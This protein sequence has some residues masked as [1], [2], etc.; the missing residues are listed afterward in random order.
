MSMDTGIPG[1]KRTAWNVDIKERSDR[2]MNYFLVCYFLVGVGLASFY[3]TWFIAFGV[4]GL[5]LVAYYSVKKLLPGSTL[6]Q[7]VLSVAIGLYMA[8]FIYQ[9]HGMFEMHFFAF[10][11]CAVLI[12]YQNWK[13]QIPLLLTIAI[14]HIVFSLL[15][16]AGY[17]K[18]YFTQ[19]DSFD[20]P[21]FSIHIL[22][23][24]VISFICGLWAYQFRKYNEVQIRQTIQV[25]EL[26]KEAL[27]TI[28][29]KR[30]EEIMEER[31]TILESIADAFFAV[32]NNWVVT[33][34][35]NMAETV[36]KKSKEDILNKCLWDVYAS[37]V[38]SASYHK[39]H[40]ALATSRPVHF[41]T[42]YQVLNKWYDVTAYPSTQGLSVYIKD[43][44]ERK[45]SEILLL[46]SEQRYSNVFQLSPL[47]IWAFDTDTL[48]FL[49]VNEAAIEHYGY[50]REEFLSMTIKDIR[51]PEDMPKLDET[52]LRSRNDGRLTKQGIYRHKRKNGD[53]IEVDV[54]SSGFAY[55]GRKAKVIVA[56]DVTATLSYIKAIEE[57]N[58][59]LKEISWIQSHVI[60]APLARILGLVQ[61]V[62]EPTTTENE[63]IEMMEYITASANELDEAIRN[64]NNKTK[65]IDNI[66]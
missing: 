45:S 42:H 14:H 48:E 39:Y 1:M 30:N 43:I 17:S 63:K 23:T 18:V 13:L 56:N 4:G 25:Q 44:T 9:V 64:I 12:T 26:R 28:E 60:R 65:T 54:Q 46:E 49:D 61:L 16:N 27:L 47:P 20:L 5:L 15:Q 50:T 52:L 11:G 53:I 51:G 10:I 31:N 22:L 29:R 38:G 33:Y 21:T 3:D 7:Y 36:L 41:E 55:K 6:Y 59:K 40:E 2:L 57:Q 19:L 32:D 35:N 66:E 8:Q 37:S 62:A 24:A 34:W 58:A